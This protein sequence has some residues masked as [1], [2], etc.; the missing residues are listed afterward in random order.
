M[1]EFMVL[2]GNSGVQLPDFKTK[3]QTKRIRTGSPVNPEFQVIKNNVFT[4][5]ITILKHELLFI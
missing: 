2:V 4:W 1:V 3:K 5:N